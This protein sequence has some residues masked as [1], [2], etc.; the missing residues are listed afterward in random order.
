MNSWIKESLP[1][2][3]QEQWR[4]LF[5]SLSQNTSIVELDVK[6]ACLDEENAQ[7]L[8]D[9]V[10]HSRNIRRAAFQ[11]EDAT[12]AFVTRLSIGIEDNYTIIDMKLHCRTRP[13]DGQWF[14]VVDTARRNTGLV[15]RASQLLSADHCDRR[16]ALALESVSSHPALLAE[17]ADVM[18]VSETNAAAMIKDVL[19]SLH[20]VHRFM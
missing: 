12:A 13:G 8:A 3:N 17:L 9:A 20:G 14:H 19:K 4:V 16:C 18:S 5:D 2:S 7:C 11:L 6:L 1:C 15:A 10:K